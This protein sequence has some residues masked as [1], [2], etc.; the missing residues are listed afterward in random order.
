MLALI[1]FGTMKIV[2]III[3]CQFEDN[4]STEQLL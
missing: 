2:N 3:N 4:Y 1:S